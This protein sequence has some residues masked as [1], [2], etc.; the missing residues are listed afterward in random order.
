MNADRASAMQPQWSPQS[1]GAGRVAAYRIG[2]DIGGTFTDF[3]V[4][5]TE[6]NRLIGLK[7]PTVPA[8]PVD[9]IVAGLKLLVEEHAVAPDRVEYFVH[10]TTIAVNALIERKGARL[11]LLVTRGFRDI[12][13]IQRLRIPQ[14]QYWY[15]NRPEPL[16]PRERVYEID[17]RIMA[18]G[19]AGTALSQESL[20]AALQQ[21]RADG[22]EGLVLCFLHAYRNPAHEKAARDFLQEEAPDLFTCCS[23]EVWPQMREYERAIVT[24]VNAYVMP[25]VSRYLGDLEQRLAQLGVPVRPYITRSNGGVMTARRARSSTA[26][27]LL[28]GPASGVIGAVRIAAQAGVRNF[29][30]LDVG[31]TS[32]DVAIVEDGAPR[33][34]LTEH[35][36]D[37]PI[38]MPVVGVSCIGAGGGSIASL[39]S[40]GVLRVG[41]QSAGADPGPACYGKGQQQPTVTDAFLYCGYLNPD[42]FA[43]GRIALHPALAQQALASLAPALGTDTGAVARGIIDIAIAGMFAELSNLAAKRGIDPREF[44]L[45]GFGGAGALLACHLAEEIG[46]TQV[47]IPQAP[48][49]LC[50]LGALSAD[51]ASDFVRSVFLHMGNDLSTVAAAY[52]QLEAEAREWF[53]TEAP[54]VKDHTLVL[55]ADMRYVGQSFEVDVPLDIAWIARG[56]W[57]A[58]TDAFHA[59]HERVYSHTQ[60]G[61]PVELI[62]L[63]LRIVG[64]T[65]KPP[66]PAPGSVPAGTPAPVAARRQLLESAAGPSDV[67]V[68]RRAEL[69]G[70]HVMA[71]P[72][73]VDQDDT[74]VYLPPGWRGTVHAS[75][76]L[77]LENTSENRG[78][79]A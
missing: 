73:L 24:I 19:S 29:I 49:T 11:G 31:G 8:R 65:T 1:K 34:S 12:L 10:G 68:H 75:G 14:P 30:T 64:S 17:E 47:L 63:R 58:V 67:P 66:L 6:T 40:A 20:R 13:I 52:A 23:H 44:T 18:D 22:V 78:D 72:A 45:V 54:A 3:A 39:D 38:M 16:I 74:T 32:A 5:E 33:T 4:H 37:F 55:S 42:T 46:I 79:A 21:A 56:D 50:A 26:E 69:A 77:L 35:V 43:G 36:A 27:T 51:V 48:G 28:S 25:P 57:Q 53:R 41:P 2:I 76:S 59:A 9:A 71:G 70:G 61:A 62:D 15:G 7:V 60:P